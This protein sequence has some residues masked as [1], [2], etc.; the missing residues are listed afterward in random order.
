[1]ADKIKVRISGT[2]RGSFSA[3]IEMTRARFDEIDK[4]LDSNERE[5]CESI[6]DLVGPDELFSC[7]RV[8][9]VDEFDAV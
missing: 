9:Y 1:M 4:L 5:A 3:E 6:F 8:D 7:A 2:V